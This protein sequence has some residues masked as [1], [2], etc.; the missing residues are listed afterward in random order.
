MTQ[1]QHFQT[2]LQLQFVANQFQIGTLLFCGVYREELYTEFFSIK[3]HLDVEHLQTRQSYY[4]FMI[5]FLTR[6]YSSL[7]LNLKHGILI[8]LVY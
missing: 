5:K 4:K 8:K 6:C 7:L 1:K 2:K 3:K